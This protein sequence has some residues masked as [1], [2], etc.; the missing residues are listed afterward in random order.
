[1]ETK[2]FF[3]F[4]IILHIS[5]SSF[6]FIWIP[7]LWVYDS[8]KYVNPFSTGTVFIHQYLTCTYV[9]FWRIRTVP[10]LKELTFLSSA[11]SV[12]WEKQHHTKTVP[13]GTLTQRHLCWFNVNVV[14]NEKH[15]IILCK[16]KRGEIN[17]WRRSRQ[18][19]KLWVDLCDLT[20]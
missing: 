12:S 20:F 2:C 18:T 7:K 10:T 19:I 9:R 8:Y 13:L 11:W 5:F 3:L 6:S 1:M 17:Q 14:I 16:G 4:E 15:I